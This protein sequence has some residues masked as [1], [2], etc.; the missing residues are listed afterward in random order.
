[1]SR[2]TWWPPL[3]LPSGGS[4]DLAFRDLPK[5]GETELLAWRL[6]R[7]LRFGFDLPPRRWLGFGGGFGV[8]AAAGGRGGWGGG[9]GAR[10][11]RAPAR[12]RGSPGRRRRAGGPR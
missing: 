4:V 11:G 10:A 8:C 6:R 7:W 3:A 2:R 12:T 1:M 5:A 9:G